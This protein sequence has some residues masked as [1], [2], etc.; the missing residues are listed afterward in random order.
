M[1]K[2]YYFITGYSEEQIKSM[3]NLRDDAVKDGDRIIIRLNELEAANANA[4]II[5][6]NAK[7]DTE[8]CL[9][10]YY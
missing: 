4:E 3:D 5:E 10:N 8:L 9:V 1:A 6:F 7:H 2:K